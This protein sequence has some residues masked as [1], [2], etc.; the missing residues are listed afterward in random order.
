MVTRQ[1]S[2]PLEE[3]TKDEL[4]FTLISKYSDEESQILENIAFKMMKENKMTLKQGRFLEHLSTY[5]ELHLENNTISFSHKTFYEIFVAKYVFRHIF[6]EEK[7]PEEFNMLM[8]DIFSDSLCSLEI[9]NYLKYLIKH[10]KL[11]ESFLKQLN[12]NFIFMIE[13]GMLT[14]SFENVDLFK[15]ISNVF[16]MMWHIVSYVNRMYC[17]GYKL[18]IPREIEPSFSCIINIFNRIYFNHVYLD[19]SY[20]DVSYIK[21]WRSNLANMNFRNSKLCHGNFMGSCLDGSNFQQADL[22]HCIFVATDLRHANLRDTNL[23]SANVSNC[24]ISEDSFK[25]FIPFKDTLRN[26]EKMIVFMNDG[27]IKKFLTLL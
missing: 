6:E 2:I 14:D 17:G 23:T 22:S 1:Q 11:N 8:W 16:Y 12:N 24:M 15:A 7:E 3:A 27:T 4:L 18:E 9:L 25:Y 19:F 10:M 5:R 26:A 13:R 20:L 21:L